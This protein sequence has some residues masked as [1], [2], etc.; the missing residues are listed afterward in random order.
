MGV[1]VS[2]DGDAFESAAP[3]LLFA[4]GSAPRD[5]DVTPDYSYDV[6]ADG[7]KFLLNE[8][9]RTDAKPSDA[10]S[11]EPQPPRE[12]PLHVIVNWSAGLR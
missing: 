11:E 7:Q 3:H 2:T 5:G 9:V 12:L 1:D 4:T 8:I 10:K 6:T